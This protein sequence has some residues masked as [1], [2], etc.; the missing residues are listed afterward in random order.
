LVEND[1]GW[2]GGLASD[3]FPVFLGLDRG[4]DSNGRCLLFS[5]CFNLHV[6]EMTLA[7]WL[8]LLVLLDSRRVRA[9]T[10]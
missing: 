6:D 2:S 3:N 10:D 1:A 5:L 7:R 4:P 9:R 8:L